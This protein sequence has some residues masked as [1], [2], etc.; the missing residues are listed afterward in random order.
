[1]NSTL[2]PGGTHKKTNDEPGVD[3]N[4]YFEDYQADF[5]FQYLKPHLENIHEPQILDVCAADGV[6]GRSI[7]NLFDNSTAFYLDIKKCG[8]SIKGGE[9][10]LN[11]NDLPGHNFL[12]GQPIERSE[13]YDIIVINPPWVPLLTAWQIYKKALTLLSPGGVLFFCINNTFVYQGRDRLPH[14][15][16]QKYYLL[17]RNVF[18]TPFNRKL[19]EDKLLKQIEVLK[20]LNYGDEQKRD[21]DIGLIQ[22]KITQQI[23]LDAGIMVYHND[24][25]VPNAGAVLKPVIMAPYKKPDPVFPGF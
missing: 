3:N 9:G 14:L 15:K 13:T 25:I 18:N 21:Y 16:F 17:P 12:I 24:G 5:I 4:Y 19:R 1:M 11:T 10:C 2:R 7:L 6:L 20:K 22:T 8:W 23:L